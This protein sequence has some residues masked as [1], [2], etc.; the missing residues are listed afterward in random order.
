MK[1]IA[2]MSSMPF[3]QLLEY[4]EQN[5][6]DKCYNALMAKKYLKSLYYNGILSN[7]EKNGIFAKL[8][9]AMPSYADDLKL[10]YQ[11]INTFF[12]VASAL[13]REILKVIRATFGNSLFLF[14]YCVGKYTNP[15]AIPTAVDILVAAAQEVLSNDAS[16]YKAQIL[17]ANSSYEHYVP[18][19]HNLYEKAIK[20]GVL[21]EK[22]DAISFGRERIS[23]LAIGE[24]IPEIKMELSDSDFELSLH[25]GDEYERYLAEKRYS[26]KPG[27][28]HSFYKCKIC[29]FCSLMSIPEE[30]K[31]AAFNMLRRQFSCMKLSDNFFFLTGTLPSYILSLISLIYIEHIKLVLFSS[32]SYIVLSKLEIRKNMLWGNSISDQDFE[33]CYSLVVEHEKLKG[34]FM[35]I[36]DGEALLIGNWMF[37][38]DIAVIECAKSVAFDCRGE[39]RLGKSTDFFG[40][41]VFEHVA[42]DILKKYNWRVVEKSIKIRESKRIITDIDLLAFKDGILMVGQLKYANCGRTPYNIWKARQTLEQAQQQVQ[43]SIQ[44]IEKD[45]HLLHSIFAQEGIKLQKSQVSCIIPVIVTSS[46]YFTSIKRTDAPTIMGFDMFEET[47]RYAQEPGSKELILRS[48]TDP[49]S[50]YRFNYNLEKVV[51]HIE[52]DEYRIIYEEYE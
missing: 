49:F 37:N 5:V 41:A 26:Q 39:N 32:H 36:K 38:M 10:H 13:Y 20:I 42:R 48:L 9:E 50:L 7:T 28:V 11:F 33:Y 51:S 18:T 34:Y 3:Q 25:Q 52:A 19:I 47:M 14:L 6:D 44:A 4:I 17:L 45:E 21:H 40:K 23:H 29:A 2:K 27:F 35:S 31:E 15:D 22:Y 12:P 1:I 30:G 24:Q 46:H 43:M 8:L 16:K